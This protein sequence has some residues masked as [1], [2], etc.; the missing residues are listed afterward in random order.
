M[1]VSVGVVRCRGVRRCEQLF[2]KLGC[3]DDDLIAST[4]YWAERSQEVLMLS[5][6]VK[7]SLTQ[8]LGP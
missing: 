5:E 7:N 3:T 6:S 1:I 4:E 2:E 8:F